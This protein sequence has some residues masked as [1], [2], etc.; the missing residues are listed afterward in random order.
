MTSASEV[1]AL[2]ATVDL[3]SG[4]DPESLARLVGVVEICEVPGG[5]VLM[6]QDET[7]EYV[8]VVLAG[9]LQVRVRDSSGRI[10]PRGPRGSGR[11]GRGDGPHQRRGP[12]R[13]G[14]RRPR[15]HVPS[16]GGR[17]VRPPGRRRPCAVA[18]DRQPDRGPDASQPSGPGGAAAGRDDHPGTAGHRDRGARSRRAPPC[19]AS[20]SGARRHEH[21][22]GRRQTPTSPPSS[23]GTPWWCSSASR[24]P[25]RGPGGASGSPT[26]WCWSPRPARMPAQREGGGVL[27][28][29]RDA[30][31]TQVDLVL[32]AIRRGR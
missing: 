31:G 30:I 2:L 22:P 9:R 8:F 4:L 18:A 26:S 1:S 13:N 28:E 21:F 32:V 29:H 17:R 3:F 11:S 7:A 14:D 6:R 12:D 19:H 5:T 25:L 23:S 24:A 20:Q 10:Q 15:L 27:G 16:P